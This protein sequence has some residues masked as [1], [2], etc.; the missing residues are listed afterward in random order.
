MRSDLSNEFLHVSGILDCAE[1]LVASDAK[2]L[3]LGALMI[4]TFTVL[5]WCDLISILICYS[6][7]RKDQYANLLSLGQPGPKLVLKSV[8]RVLWVNVNVAD[9]AESLESP[10]HF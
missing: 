8:E 3:F 7:T 4:P 9:A 10:E 2:H 5:S 6:G 1:I